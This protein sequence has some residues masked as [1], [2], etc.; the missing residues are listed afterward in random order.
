MPVVPHSAS[1]SSL[2][3]APAQ[4]LPDDD[5]LEEFFQYNF[6]NILRLFLRCVSIFL[7]SLHSIE[8]GH[9][10]LLNYLEN[11]GGTNLAGPIWMNKSK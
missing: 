1:T 7:E 3:L 6:M 8:L 5:P 4:T 11:I 9:P 2:V 10:M